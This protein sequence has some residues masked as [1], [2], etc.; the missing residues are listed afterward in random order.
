MFLKFIRI[1]NS[2]IDRIERIFKVLEY[3]RLYIENNIH[4]KLNLQ[5]SIKI[6]YF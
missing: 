1:L 3:I 5:F 6:V 4:E 2:I